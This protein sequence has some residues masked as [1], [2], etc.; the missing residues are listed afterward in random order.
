[1]IRR[2]QPLPLAILLLLTFGCAQYRGLVSAPLTGFLS[3]VPEVES[4]S[5]IGYLPFNHSWK[6]DE[7]DITQFN[8]LFIP[9]V[10][11]QYLRPGGFDA[12]ISAFTPTKDAYL[13]Q[14]RLLGD[15]FR[16]QLI[17][18]NQSHSERAIHNHRSA[19]A[20]L[21]RDRTCL[22]GSLLRTSGCLCGF[23]GLACPGHFDCR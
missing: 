17:E 6:K 10:N 14:T 2:S 20:G 4:S 18:K 22:D 8:K 13:E 11:M 3:Q 21:A 19:R 1:M 12:S 15:Y 7:F 9:P 23:D 16:E 5:K